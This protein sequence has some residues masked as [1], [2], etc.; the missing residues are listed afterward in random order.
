LKHDHNRP[1]ALFDSIHGIEPIGGG[2]RRTLQVVNLAQRAGFDLA[3]VSMVNVPEFR[4]RV[5][6]GLAAA[7]RCRLP[8]RP[9]L[10][11]LRDLGIAVLAYRHQFQDA[12]NPRLVLWETTRD[13]GMVAPIVAKQY[14]AAIVAFPQNLESLVPGQTDRV[15]GTNSVANALEIEVRQLAK[16]DLVVCI[17]REEQW[18]LKAFG[19]AADFLPYF[20]TTEIES[21]LLALRRKRLDV[22][23]RRL[24]IL[25][26]AGN[27]PSREGLVQLIR[28]L[29]RLR[30]RFP[31]EIH[32]AGN[33]TRVLPQQLGIDSIKFHGHLDLDQLYELLVSSEKAVV[34][35]TR[36]SG[37]LTRIPELLL[38]GLP[39]ICNPH[40]ARSAQ[41]YDGVHIF[42]TD[43][44]LVSLLNS[45]VL[46]PR[47]PSRPV[48]AE[49]R[50]IK[51]LRQ[52]GGLANANSGERALLACS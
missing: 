39:V 50:L 51:R 19:I 32:V 15:I 35:Q 30:G 36:G 17:S 33:D 3:H 22:T 47:A 41:H 44:E 48:R 40:A 20:P 9:S 14:G 29:L 1:T 8:V 18:L 5:Y 31:H 28:R 37:A 52:L 46:I 11:V 27:P 16:A 23:P 38:A 24:L 25:G 45:T 10:E 4:N 42:D 13:Q 7:V 34:F 2:Q 26:S 43:E 21:D 6:E 49:E 12:H